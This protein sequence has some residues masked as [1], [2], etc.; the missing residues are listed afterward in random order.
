MKRGPKIKPGQVW[1]DKKSGD[2]MQ[3]NSRNHDII[4]NCTFTRSIKSHKIPEF[5][6]YKFYTI[7]S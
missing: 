2:I 3:I 1:V 5:V 7:A 4:W 6:I